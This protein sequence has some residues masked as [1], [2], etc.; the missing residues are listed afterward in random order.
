MQ[1]STIPPFNNQTGATLLELVVGILIVAMLIGLSVFGAMAFRESRK[2]DRSF[3]A[4]YQLKEAIKLHKG[5][6]AS[7]SDSLYNTVWTSNLIPDQF[8]KDDRR[9]IIYTAMGHP[10]GVTGRG[11][12]FSIEIYALSEAECPVIMKKLLEPQYFP[13]GN[14]SDDL[15]LIKLGNMVFDDEKLPRPETIDIA[16]RSG[17]SVDLILAFR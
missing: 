4:I 17:I 13:L 2:I 8:D 16:C 12:H 3:T 1:K 5:N 15:D 7:Y 14:I 10:V 11:Q 9:K 6:S